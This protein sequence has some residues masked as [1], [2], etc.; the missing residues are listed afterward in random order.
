[1]TCSEVKWWVSDGNQTQCH[2][3][4]ELARLQQY[5]QIELI[6]Y[7]YSKDEI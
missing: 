3:Q 6:M 5:T 2:E 7:E 1:V 4:L